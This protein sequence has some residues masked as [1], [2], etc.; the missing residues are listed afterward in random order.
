MIHFVRVIRQF[1]VGVGIVGL[2]A[3]SCDI[4]WLLQTRPS[5]DLTIEFALLI[6]PL[7]SSLCALWLG[8]FFLRSL[9][10]E[11]QSMRVI[12]CEQG[13]LKIRRGKRHLH[14]EA[15]HWQDM[16]LVRMSYLSK[17]NL[18]VSRGKGAYMVLSKS[19][20]DLDEFV[21]LIKQRL[22]DKF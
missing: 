12:I 21:A 2:T 8:L 14:A 3:V 15:L 17:K 1:C 20:Q 6:P 9:V 19:Y 16:E 13:L 11:L 5:Q 4:L 10:S 22:G 7:G 18:I